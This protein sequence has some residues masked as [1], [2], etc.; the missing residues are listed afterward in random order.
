M[1]A[2]G[3]ILRVKICKGEFPLAT[4]GLR[5]GI[6]VASCRPI[7]CVTD[8]QLPK[9]DGVRTLPLIA[10]ERGAAEMDDDD[11]TGADRTARAIQTLMA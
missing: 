6:A 8:K 3:L 1:P 11:A 4:G 2:L 9:A 5:H 10:K 7:R